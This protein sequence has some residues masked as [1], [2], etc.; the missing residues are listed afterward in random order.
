MKAAPTSK[1]PFDEKRNIRLT[2]GKVF[3]VESGAT[4]PIVEPARFPTPQPIDG[5]MAIPTSFGRGRDAYCAAQATRVGPA[6]SHC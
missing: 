1:I 5:W 2:E 4:A 6:G 3:H